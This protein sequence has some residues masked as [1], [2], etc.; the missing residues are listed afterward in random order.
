MDVGSA[1]EDVLAAQLLAHVHCGRTDKALAAAEAATQLLPSSSSL[2]LLRIKLAGCLVQSAASEAGPNGHQ[3]VPSSVD[4]SDSSDDSGPS[5]SSSPLAAEQLQA[6]RRSRVRLLFGR[7][8]RRFSDVEADQ[9]LASP[10]GAAV[11]EMSASWSASNV[12]G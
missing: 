5:P 7:G 6:T 9:L 2:W 4:D 3:A 12:R 10:Q 8:G 11:E 1:T